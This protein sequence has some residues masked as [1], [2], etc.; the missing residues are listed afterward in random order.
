MASRAREFSVVLQDRP[1]ALADLAEALGRNGV[2]IEAIAAV[3]SGGRGDVRV[4]IGDAA[5]ARQALSRT[6]IAIGAERD[7]LLVDL[8][9]VPG[10]LAAVARKL[11]DAGVNIDALYVVGESGG[12]KRIALG[13]DDLDKAEGALG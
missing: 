2:N 13:A 8:E 3:P 10:A 1:G 11:G 4:V 12:R 6:G 9:H 7:V 5:G